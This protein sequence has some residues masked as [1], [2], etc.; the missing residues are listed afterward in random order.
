MT[1]ASDLEN[2]NKQKKTDI[3]FCHPSH[4]SP[5]GNSL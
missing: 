2:K 1:V 4:L 3:K 5:I